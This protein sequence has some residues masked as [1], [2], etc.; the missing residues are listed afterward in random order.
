[1]VRNSHEP[2][3]CHYIEQSILHNMLHAPRKVYGVPACLRIACLHNNQLPKVRDAVY[4]QLRANSLHALLVSP[5]ALAVG[6]RVGELM[7]SLPPVAFACID[8]AHCISQWS[9]NFRPSYLMICQG[10]IWFLQQPGLE[11][12]LEVL[13][14]SASLEVLWKMIEE[15]FPHST[16]NTFSAG[17]ADPRGKRRRS[18][19]RHADPRGV[20]IVSTIAQCEPSSRPGRFL[21]VERGVWFRVDLDLYFVSVSRVF[22]MC[23]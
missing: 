9:H 13:L 10:V 2:N 19:A 17:P 16:L 20:A 14:I 23:K 3:Q 12:C 6:D 4:E 8:E 7:R 22:S 18:S 5:E 11:C 21:L 15:F 1:M